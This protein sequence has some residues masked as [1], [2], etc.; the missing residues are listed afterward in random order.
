MPDSPLP[1][2]ILILNSSLSIQRE[3]AGL[4]LQK[5]PLYRPT[6]SMLVNEDHVEASHPFISNFL[7]TGNQAVADW[8]AVGRVQKSPALMA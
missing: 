8:I 1:A 4:C 2:F 7:T 3:F 6:P 5:N